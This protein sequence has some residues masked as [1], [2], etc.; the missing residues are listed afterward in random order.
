M[1]SQRANLSDFLFQLL[2]PPCPFEE[3]QVASMK[4]LWPFKVTRD[5]GQGFPE[6]CLRY[7]G[8]SRKASWDGLKG[9][10]S[11]IL[12]SPISVPCSQPGLL[13]HWNLSNLRV[14][15]GQMF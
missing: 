15:E 8:S 14:K 10:G 1:G 9:E 2:G 13:L 6:V 12:P 5:P 4:G 3:L 7:L 11:L